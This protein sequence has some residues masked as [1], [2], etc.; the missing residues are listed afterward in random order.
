MGTN[1]EDMAGHE[2]G[3]CLYSKMVCKL[4]CDVGL[5]LDNKAIIIIEWNRGMC[6][7]LGGWR[8]HTT[9]TT[10]ID[11]AAIKPEGSDISPPTIKLA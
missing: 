2:D 4:R 7:W 6:V 3:A 11:S 9:D 8:N 10:L 5:D 1:N